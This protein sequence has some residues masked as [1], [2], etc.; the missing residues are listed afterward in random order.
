MGAVV[1]REGWGCHHV[2]LEYFMTGTE[3]ILL[4]NRTICLFQTVSNFKV[5]TYISLRFTWLL[6]RPTVAA[7]SQQAKM[8]LTQRKGS[9]RTGV[10]CMVCECH[11]RGPQ[12]QSQAWRFAR[13]THR[14]Q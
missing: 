11:F 13:R 5:F 6:E 4:C 3:P 7:V 14:T 12:D 8:G 2:R 10:V 9:E 1:R